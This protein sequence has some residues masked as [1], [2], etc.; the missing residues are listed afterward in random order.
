MEESAIISSRM[1][2]KTVTEFT[3]NIMEEYIE[4]S[5][6]MATMTVMDS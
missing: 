5:T 3:H 2:L 1:V 6:K 4:E